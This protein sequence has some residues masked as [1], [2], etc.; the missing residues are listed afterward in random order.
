MGI[1][2]P[3]S[4]DD[5]AVDWLQDYTPSDS[6]RP[7]GWFEIPRDITRRINSEKFPEG[8]TRYG[9]TAVEAECRRVLLAGEGARNNTLW[10]SGCKIGQLVGGGEVELGHAIGSLR[11][12]ALSA[13]LSH[14]EVDRVLVRRAGAIESGIWQPRNR[15]GPLAEQL[16][17]KVLRRSSFNQ[18]LFVLG[19]FDSWHS[20]L[21]PDSPGFA[22]LNLQWQI[23]QLGVLYWANYVYFVNELHL[24]SL[25][26]ARGTKQIYELLNTQFLAQA[27]DWEKLWVKSELALSTV[28]ANTPRDYEGL[29]PEVY[30][31]AEHVEEIS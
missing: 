21:D 26:G 3:A 5:E 15:F 27:S 13:G 20:N 2:P 6:L 31:A 9:L 14:E 19:T 7:N 22:C 8:G 12:S 29:C 16:S 23:Q 1:I 10:S 28:I 4:P 30:D 24:L 25:S 18:N 11:V 17:K